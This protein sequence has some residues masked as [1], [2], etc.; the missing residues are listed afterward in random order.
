M[1]FF[2]LHPMRLNAESGRASYSDPSQPILI[3]SVQEDF[4]SV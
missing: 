1:R 3:G 4:I 2:Y